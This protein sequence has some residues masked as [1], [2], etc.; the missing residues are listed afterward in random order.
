M[1][2]LLAFVGGLV[3]FGALAGTTNFAKMLAH[4]RCSHTDGIRKEKTREPSVLGPTS[5]SLRKSIRNIMSSFWVFLGRATA[6]QMAEDRRAEVRALLCE[7]LFSFVLGYLICRWL[8]IFM[9]CR[10]Y[11]RRPLKGLLGSGRL[12]PWRLLHQRLLLRVLL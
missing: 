5:D 8:S 9:T 3:D 10:S 11:R 7:L 6:K 2:K 1:E 4:G 12:R